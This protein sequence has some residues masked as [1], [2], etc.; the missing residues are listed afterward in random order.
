MTTATRPA[1]EGFDE[2]LT[3]GEYF[4]LHAASAASMFGYQPPAMASS[5]PRAL[6]LLAKGAAISDRQAELVNAVVKSL[7]AFGPTAGQAVEAMYRA[8]ERRLADPYVDVIRKAGPEPGRHSDW[9]HDWTVS[10]AATFAVT[11]HEAARCYV[12]ST[13][14]G[15]A[16]AAVLDEHS[17]GGRTIRG[18]VG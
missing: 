1:P 12:P 4:R 3:S 14:I 5:Y 2:K 10:D 13:G 15:W 6:A 11:L 17:L 7:S 9:T 18:E 8:A 16:L